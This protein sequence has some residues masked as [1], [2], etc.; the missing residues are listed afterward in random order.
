MLTAKQTTLDEVQKLIQVKDDHIAELERHLSNKDKTIQEYQATISSLK[1][2]HDSWA[3]YMHLLTAEMSEMA[4]AQREREG[5]A[6]A[7][8]G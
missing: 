4:P 5:A 8:G 2:W 6:A 7:A 1:E 3:P